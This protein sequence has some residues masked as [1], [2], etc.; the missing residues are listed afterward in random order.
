[1]VSLQFINTYSSVLSE[2]IEVTLLVPV[3]VPK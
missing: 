3:S 1:M 2:D